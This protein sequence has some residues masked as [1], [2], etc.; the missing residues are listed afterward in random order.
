M[1]MKNN[2]T[3]IYIVRHGESES[4]V[5]TDKPH[6]F[7]KQWGELEAPLTKNGEEQARKRAKHLQHIHFDAVFSSDLTRA[8]QTAEIIALE[9]ELTIQ[10]TRLIRERSYFPY[11]HKVYEETGKTKE[12]IEEEM[13]H[14]LQKLDENAK[15]AYKHGEGMESPEE[16]VS[17]FITFLREIAIAYLGKTVLVINHGNNMRSLLTHLG[18]AKFD[19][20]AGNAV[21]NTGYIV[22]TSDGVDFFVKD[23]YGINKQ[24]QKT[25]IL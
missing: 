24:Q 12:E 6:L 5:N 10:T 7:H 14:E 4:N 1:M 9:K 13:R 3:T 11:I 19:E 23:T 25:R 2:L 21:E 17:R 8:K 15:M 18:W 16:A 22:L 20:L